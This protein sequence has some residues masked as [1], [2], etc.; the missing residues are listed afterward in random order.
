MKTANKIIK[1]N[2]TVDK[3]V[4]ILQKYGAMHIKVYGDSI[5]S[6][7]PIHKGDNKTAFHVKISNMLWYCH[8]QCDTGGDIFDFYAKIYNLDVDND[9]KQIINIVAYDLGIDITNAVIEK[10]SIEEQREILNFIKMIKQKKEKTEFKEFD[11]SKY[12]ELKR[13][14]KLRDFEEEIL[15]RFEISYSALFKKIVCPI[16][17][18]NKI[19]GVQLRAT[20]NTTPKWITQPEGLQVGKILYNYDNLDF[21]KNYCIITEG[22]F[23]VLKLTQL[24]YN[25]VVAT[26]GAHITNDQIKLL[27]PFTK[28]IICYDNDIAGQNATLKAI[29][30]LQNMFNLLIVDLG[31]FKDAGCLAFKEE[32]KF[33]KPQ[34]YIKNLK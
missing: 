24:G 22:I 11:L 9:F 14:I 1:E 21:D 13:I 8:T 25:N 34:T 10:R 29:T 31:D 28:I 20:D 27:M 5:R 32:I 2:L 19:I 23:D 26:F 4:Y 7:C 15:D 12:G 17:F 16:R 3:M 30:K 6:T 33:I 18:N